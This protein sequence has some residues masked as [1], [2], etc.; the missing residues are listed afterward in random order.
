[1]RNREFKIGDTV[2]IKNGLRGGA[3]YGKIYF[4]PRMEQGC[5]KVTKISSVNDLRKYEDGRF[6]SIT[7][8]FLEEYG[9][10]WSWTAEMLEPCCVVGGVPVPVSENIYMEDGDKDV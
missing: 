1:M 7:T 9:S 8:Y 4:N 2:M 10:R 5:G 3:S 6:I